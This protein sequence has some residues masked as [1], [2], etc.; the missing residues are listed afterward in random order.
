MIK[1][2]NKWKTVSK[3]YKIVDVLG[4]GAGGVVVQGIHR[5][6]KKIVAIKRIDFDVERLD[7]FKYILREI[8]IMRQLSQI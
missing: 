3:D 5:A 4:Q 6:S 8:T 2:D 7:Q 1:L